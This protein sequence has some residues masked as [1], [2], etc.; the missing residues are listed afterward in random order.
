MSTAGTLSADRIAAGSIDT[1]K[2][3]FTPVSGSNVVATINASS[4]GLTID[5]D[6]LDLSGVYQ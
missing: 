6:T 3:N 4:E 1:S 5:A 2:L